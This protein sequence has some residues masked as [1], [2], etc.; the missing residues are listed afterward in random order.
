MLV[1][2]ANCDMFTPDVAKNAPHQ[3]FSP[4]PALRSRPTLVWYA[5][6]LSGPS[7][8][9]QNFR[10]GYK[11][12]KSTSISVSRLARNKERKSDEFVSSYA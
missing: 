12:R 3:P 7:T 5:K 4:P 2:Q 6:T 11:Q 9:P 1:M 10:A 8:R